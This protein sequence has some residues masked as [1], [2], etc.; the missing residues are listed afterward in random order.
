[1][2][3]RRDDP[4]VDSKYSISPPVVGYQPSTLGFIAQYIKH[5]LSPDNPVG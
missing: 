4:E 1:M 2:T 5:S 3:L